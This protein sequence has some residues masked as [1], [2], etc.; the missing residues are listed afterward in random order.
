MLL[1]QEK[2]ARISQGI[3]LT[4]DVKVQEVEPNLTDIRMKLANLGGAKS[5]TGGTDGGREIGA[6]LA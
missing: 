4:R 6:I 2:K 3:R 5:G 1:Q